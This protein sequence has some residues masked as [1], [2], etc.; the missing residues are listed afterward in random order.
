MATETGN[1][2]ALELKKLCLEVQQLELRWWKRPSYIAAAIPIVLALLTLITAF[3]TGWFDQER[4]NLR[5]QKDALEAQ[6]AV[7][8]QQKTQLEEQ[9]NA[10]ESLNKK[11]QAENINL[12]D[13]LDELEEA[14]SSL[15]EDLNTQSGNALN[16]GQQDTIVEVTSPSSWLIVFSTDPELSIDEPISAEYEVVLAQ[17]KLRKDSVILKRGSLYSTAIMFESEEAAQGELERIRDELS[18]PAAFVTSLEGFCSQPEVENDRSVRG[19]TKY[20]YSLYT[21]GN[22]D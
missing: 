20:P 19:G 6:N 9:K 16:A 15:R 21:C 12:E 10:L 8:E 3:T 14:E 7:L 17:D 18:R 2:D 22:G 13:S 11:L 1:R 4:S 5:S